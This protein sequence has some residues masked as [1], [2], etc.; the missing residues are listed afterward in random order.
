M[1]AS[2]VGD[3]EEALGEASLVVTATTSAEPVLPE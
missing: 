2:V 3:V 1:E